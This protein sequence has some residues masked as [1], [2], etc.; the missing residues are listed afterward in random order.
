MSMWHCDVTRILEIKSH[1]GADLLEIARVWDYEV[2]IRKG[3]FNPGDK[4]AYLAV[5]TIC[6]GHPAFAFLGKDAFRP[7]RA[8]R[9]RGIF[10]QGLLVEA[11]EG[12]EEGQSVVE[13]FGLTRAPEKE[14]KIE[15]KISRGS[16]GLKVYGTSGHTE[17]PPFPMSVY[18]LLPL[19]KYRDVFAE[20]E[21][22]VITEK[23]D[24]E[25][26]SMVYHKGRLWVRSRQHWKKRDPDSR[27]WT[28]ALRDDYEAKLEK[29]PDLIFLGELYGNVSHFRYDCPVNDGY[30]ERR[31]RVFDIWDR[32]EGRYLG[33]DRVEEICHSLGIPTVPVLYRG[34]WKID[35]SL[36][37]LAE[38][39]STLN[40]N[41]IREGFV[42]RP[43]SSEEKDE[44][45][46][47]R[48]TLKLISPEYLLLK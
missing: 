7:L 32:I 46:S 38:G 48:R 39:R 26:H 9:L 15:G 17:S 34:P 6:G 13:H 2:V 24:G 40:G 23:I 44:V 35:R 31:F 16:D 3:Q 43:A 14:E 4:V 12:L 19:K 21:E 47:F 42:V 18:D 5:E 36:Y 1:P 11:P 27:W 33:Y 28:V 20:G 30:V 29:Y 10:S 41:V 8:K 22:V 37:P 25:N 45:F